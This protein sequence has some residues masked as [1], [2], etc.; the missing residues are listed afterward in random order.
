MASTRE[1]NSRARKNEETFAQANDQIR[2][3]AERNDFGHPV[4]FLCECSQ[5]TC[6]ET[7]RLSLTTYRS[8]KDTSDAFILLPGHDDPG[9]EQ[10]V[11]H[12]DGYVL[13]EKFA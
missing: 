2:D 9:V 8:E 5:V 3:S 11:A 12:R 4:P 6:T 7:V 13:V 10:I 1:T